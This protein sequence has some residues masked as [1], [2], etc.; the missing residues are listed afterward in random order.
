MM[1][2]RIFEKVKQKLE[3]EKKN[4]GCEMR[5]HCDWNERKKNAEKRER[6]M[7][8]QTEIERRKEKKGQKKEEKVQNSCVKRKKRNDS[9]VVSFC[10]CCCY[11]WDWRWCCGCSLMLLCDC[12]WTVHFHFTRAV[13]F[14]CQWWLSQSHSDRSVCFRVRCKM[15]SMKGKRIQMCEAKQ[16]IEK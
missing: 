3:K 16:E 9:R 1:Q 8:K 15:L 6:K 13:V 5:K 2:G 7:R 12:V 10:C 11:L 14:A 4:E